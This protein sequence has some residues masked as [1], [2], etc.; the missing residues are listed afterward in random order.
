MAIQKD[1]SGN[2]HIMKGFYQYFNR[3]S[4]FLKVLQL[5]KEHYGEIYY[6]A[7]F[8]YT[9]TDLS[10]QRHIGIGV[11]SPQNAHSALNLPYGLVGIGRSSNYIE[12]L[13]VSYPTIIKPNTRVWSPIIP[14][15]QIIIKPH[16]TN[17][18][19]YFL[20]IFNLQGG[21]LSFL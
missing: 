18:L 10:G 5:Q 1:N 20:L 7:Q 9:Y 2:K 3:D 14:N 16:M 13:H 8:T 4:F 19:K 11:Q 21:K 12:H 15:S 6:G 17:S